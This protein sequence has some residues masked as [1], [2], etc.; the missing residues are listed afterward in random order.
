MS[1]IIAANKN[2]LYDH[3]SGGGRQFCFFDAPVHLHIASGK[4]IAK[5]LTQ[6]DA[7]VIILAN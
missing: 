7:E 1:S 3:F 5:A 4:A 2:Y 6:E